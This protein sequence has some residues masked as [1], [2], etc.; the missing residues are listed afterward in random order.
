MRVELKSVQRFT[1]YFANRQTITY[2]IASSLR[3]V[4]GLFDLHALKKA[5]NHLNNNKHLLHVSSCMQWE[6]VKLFVCTSFILISQSPH[7]L[8]VSGEQAGG[9]KKVQSNIDTLF[10]QENTVFK[11]HSLCAWLC[12]NGSNQTANITKINKKRKKPTGEVR[13]ASCTPLNPICIDVL[14]WPIN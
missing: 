3:L 4:I 13:P 5:Q 2:T 6:K 8:T 1:W 7:K 9:K 11:L 14:I 10:L 12:Q